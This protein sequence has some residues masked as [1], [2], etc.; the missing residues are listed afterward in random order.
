MQDPNKGKKF[1]S[2]TIITHSS[3]D[4]FLRKII[5]EISKK[6]YIKKK[7]KLIRIDGN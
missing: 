4:Q 2:I 3:K 5:K 6:H 7:P 1:S